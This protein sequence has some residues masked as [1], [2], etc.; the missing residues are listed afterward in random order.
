MNR[1][2]A[3][4]ERPAKLTAMD[5]AKKNRF[6]EEASQVVAPC[7]DLATTLDFFMRE[8]GFHLEM[9]FPADRPRVAVIAGRGVRLRLDAKAAGSPVTLRLPCEASE[10]PR[11]LIAPGG[12]TI[13][14]VSPLAPV[15]VPPLRPEFVLVDPPSQ[16]AWNTGRAGMLY[17]DLIPGRLG[18]RF[19]ASHIRIPDGGPVPDYVHFHRVRFQMIYCRRGWVR[20]VY[21]DQGPPFTLDA[22]DAVLQPPGIRHRVLECSPGLEVVE[23]SSPAEHATYTDP[24][25]DLPNDD[26]RPEALFGGQRFVRHQAQRAAWKSDRWPS[27]ESRDI[28]FGHATGGLADARVLRLRGPTESTDLTH[29]DE[30]LFLFALRGHATLCDDEGG[31]HPLAEAASA[32]IPPDR[33][34]TLSSPSEDLTLLRVQVSRKT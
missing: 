31:D 14:L 1:R 25:L 34:F 2:F 17:R 13:D 21:E 26:V 4:S 19:I 5:E 8:L 15:E 11:V 29:T 12:T 22:G 16:D 23:L 30:L 10:E 20:V 3:K 18:G 33:P 9:I 28:G 32:A 27:F 7:A 6:P 24:D